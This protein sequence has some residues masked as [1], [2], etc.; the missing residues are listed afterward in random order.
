MW[1]TNGSQ[2]ACVTKAPDT[3]KYQCKIEHYKVIIENACY[4]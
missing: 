3:L 1:G 4:T 2:T